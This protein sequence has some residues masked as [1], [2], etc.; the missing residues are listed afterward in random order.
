V[1]RDGVPDLIHRVAADLE[2]QGHAETNALALAV[3]TI[4]RWQGRVRPEIKSRIT[5][6]L[7][8]FDA[9]RRKLPG[10]TQRAL[11]ELQRVRIKPEE[12]RALAEAAWHR[13]TVAEGLMLALKTGNEQAKRM[14]LASAVS[15]LGDDVSALGEAEESIR[16]VRRRLDGIVERDRV[17]TEAAGYRQQSRLA[18][19]PVHDASAPSLGG[20]ATPV[21]TKGRT[22]QP[23]K[24]P[25]FEKKHPRLAKGRVGGGQFTLKRGTGMEGEPDQRVRELQ[26]RLSG[27]RLGGRGRLVVAPDGRYGP[28]TEQAV[29]AFQRS[30]G[31]PVSGDVD[32]ATLET[33]R[34]PPLNADGTVRTVEQLRSEE[35][36]AEQTSGSSRKQGSSRSSRSGGRE[37]AEVDTSSPAAIRKFQRE[38]GLRVTGKLD[39]PTSAAVRAVERDR[40]RRGK[41]ERKGGR[42]RKGD[43]TER[44]ADGT[45]RQG[46]GMK[47]SPS[48]EVRRYQQILEE[49]GFDLGEGA[50][51]GRFGPATLAAVRRFQRQNGLRVDGIIGPQTIAAL[52]RALREKKREKPQA[53]GG[54]MSVREAQQ[55]KAEKLRQLHVGY[56]EAVAWRENAEG[57]M[58]FV[59]ANAR[60][61]ARGLRLVEAA[62]EWPEFGEALRE[63]GSDLEAARVVCEVVEGENVTLQEAVLAAKQR[64]PAPILEA[65]AT[66]KLKCPKCGRVQ[67]ASNAKCEN[68]GHGLAQARK[69]K[70][71]K[72]REGALSEEQAREVLVLLPFA[73]LSEDDHATVV[74]RATALLGLIEDSGDEEIDEA[75]GEA[76]LTAKER[77]KL[78]QS[79]FALSGGRYPIHDEAHARNALARVS[80]HGTPEEQKRVR[81]AVCRRYPKMCEDSKKKAQEAVQVFLDAAYIDER[82]EEVKSAAYPSLERVPGKQNWVD[83]AGGLPSYIERIAKHLHYEKGMTIGRAIAVAVN[84]VRKMCASGDVN[85]PGAQQ[86]NVKSRAQACAAVA[87]WEKKKAS[88]RAKEAVLLIEAAEREFSAKELTLSLEEC[89]EIAVAAEEVADEP[90]KSGMALSESVG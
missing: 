24:D 30:L 53:L 68:C 73:E 40:A 67:D 20:V 84:A 12:M 70:F 15:L 48:A 26:Q 85:F 65:E 29:K 75:L 87:S 19:A 18:E 86:V 28:V 39:G 60:V 77:K 51:D 49:L 22:G 89:Y 69:A 5:E 88:A 80:Q 10:E 46:D 31:L 36:A 11:R 52:Q 90:V 74:R 79:A 33:L 7:R 35:R 27:L 66:Y 64:R 41:S 54:D 78:P 34:N 23:V 44:R 14:A 57:G 9:S 50:V 63:T 8:E 21:K 3:G 81:A 58:E 61:E 38:H 56:D 62:R 43:S 42:A 37:S 25:E 17:V 45:V 13:R 4:R 55:S 76:V 82:L 47:G 72:M 83:K 6:A 59:R 1:G 32:E 2:A 71:A 16:E